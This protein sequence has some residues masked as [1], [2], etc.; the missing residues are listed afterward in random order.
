MSDMSHV[1]PLLLVG[2]HRLTSRPPTVWFVDG[3]AQLV[4]AVEAHGAFDAGARQRGAVYARIGRVGHVE[5]DWSAGRLTVTGIVRGSTSYDTRLTAARTPSGAVELHTACSCPVGAGCKHAYALVVTLRDQLVPRRPHWRSVLDAVL[6]ETSVAAETQ[7]GPAA[8]VAVELVLPK[9]R[10]AS[11]FG[12]EQDRAPRVEVRAL[13]RGTSGRWVRGGMEWSRVGTEPYAGPWAGVRVAATV[14]PVDLDALAELK[15][16]LLGRRGYLV[17]ASDGLD[18]HGSGPGLWR[19]LDRLAERGIPLLCSER[20]V[21]VEVSALPAAPGVDVSAR[22]E[23]VAVHA[24]VTLDGTWCDARDVRLVGDPAH[25]VLLRY[26]TGAAGASTDGASRLVL[27]R[28]DRPLSPALR[29]WFDESAPLTVEPSALAELVGDY[30]P[31]IAQ[32]VPVVSRDGSVDLPGPADVSLHGD[33]TWDDEGGFDLGWRWHYRRGDQTQ[34][35]PADGPTQ[36]RG[37]RDRAAEVALVQRLGWGDDLDVLLGLGLHGPG[38][39]TP[40][41][42]LRD[43]EAIRFAGVHLPRLQAHPDVE[44]ITNGAPAG[45]REATGVPEVRF[46]ERGAAARKNRTD[47]LDLEVVVSVDDEEHGTLV[48]GLPRVLAALASGDTKVLI[49]KGV[50]VDLDRPELDRLAR[51]VQDARSLAD[52]PADGLRLTREAHGLLAEVRE[53]GATE[54]QLAQWAAAS[55]A[56]RDLAESDQPLPVVPLPSALRAE[57]R[58]YQEQGY[59]WLDFLRRHA[60]GGVLADDMGLGKTLQTLAMI[61]RALESVGDGGERRPFLV[62]APSSVVGT[63]RSEAARFTPDLHVLPITAST[64]RRGWPLRQA[65]AGPE[66]VDVVVTTY[67]LLRLEAE[68]YAE[69]S[70]AGLVLDEAQMVKNH[71]SKTWAAVRD[72]SALSRFAIT[73]TPLENNLMELWAILSLTAPGLYPYA[74]SFRTTVAQPIEQDADRDVRT[75]LLRRIRPVLLRRTK[76]LVAADLPAKQ[77]QLVEVELSPRHRTLYDTHLQRE[78]QRILQLLDEDPEGSRIT[79]LASLTKLRQLSLDPA[80][81]DPAHD[82]VG[83]AK[84]D[85]LVDQLAEVVGE[86]HR[87]LVFSQFTGFLGRVRARLDAERIPYAYLDGRTRRREQVVD[88]FRSGTVPVFLISLKAGGVG[89][90]LTEADYC[91]VLDP[92]WN[93]AVEAQAVDRTHRIGQTRPVMVYRYVAVDTVEQKVVELSARKAKLFASVLDGDADLGQ[94]LT[95]ADIAAIVG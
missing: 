80:L 90:N 30:L 65:I 33:L 44:V 43:A 81:V 77:E 61:S 70:W 13:R 78:R 3:V 56:L 31:S 38:S 52:Q 32:A 76:E 4:A 91:F 60:L 73:G 5:P 29:S 7:A 82:G 53:I 34:Q 66:P 88:G 45:F 46:A 94:G 14:D 68:Q 93:P 6:D 24:G 10:P 18:L 69:I 47:W 74:E 86:G 42:R 67:T 87:A 62:V 51:L 9:H 11:R 19:A 12:R 17:T 89:L 95:A 85:Q 28:L 27:A 63:W 23:S 35:F 36:P 25:G 1:Y 58:P 59:Q 64:A 57:L 22:G 15:I 37:W 92:W 83:S 49:R 41:F 79:I 2:K 84:I 16:A 72:L 55:A 75:A 8:P 40:R 50:W 21:E 26:G 71:R 39:L 20:E 54:G 48:L